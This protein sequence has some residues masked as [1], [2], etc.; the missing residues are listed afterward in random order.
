MA[1]DIE[2]CVKVVDTSRHQAGPTP[3]PEPATPS[4]SGLLAQESG[5]VPGELRIPEKK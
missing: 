1:T 4:G 5:D 3:G 2:Q